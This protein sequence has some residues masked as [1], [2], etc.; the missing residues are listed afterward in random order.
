LMCGLAAHDQSPYKQVVIY[1]WVVDGEGKQMHKSGGNAISPNE[2]V[3]K[4]GAEI[5][6]LWASAMD[7]TQDMRCSDEILSRIVDAYRKFRNTLRYALG[8]LDGFNPETDTVAL[9]EMQEID[10]WALASLDEA[11]EKVGTGYEMYNFQAVYQTLYNFVT[12]TL[13]AR[14]FDIIKDRLYIYAPRSVE[15]RSAQTALYKITDNL[16]R[17]LAPILAFTADEAF[18]NLP[19]QKLASVHLAEFPKVSGADDLPLLKDWERIFSI[20]DEVLKAL[21]E[22]RNAKQIGSSLE[23]KVILTVDKDTTY[24]LLPYYEDLRYIFIVSQVEVHQGDA[25]NVEIQKAD[26]AKCER[27]WNYSIHVGESEKYPSVC[28]RC[29]EA[30]SEI[31]QTATA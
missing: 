26:G 18:E 2:V 27:C 9:R 14:Y 30:L 25:F 4:S 23:A 5:L 10:R 24:F 17:L 3:Q 12:V 21:E 28:E 31:E 20:R 1:G 11:I 6:R 15:R 7:S 13:S 8:N 22:A 29:L 16:S 19:H